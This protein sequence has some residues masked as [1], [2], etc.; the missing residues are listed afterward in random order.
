MGWD[1]AAQAAVP[2]NYAAEVSVG[3]V[4]GDARLFEYRLGYA[5]GPDEYFLA[6]TPLD[7]QYHVFVDSAG[8]ASWRPNDA[9]KTGRQTNTLRVEVVNDELTVYLN[10]KMLERFPRAGLS[11]GRGNVIVGVHLNGPFE[12]AEVEVQ[13]KDFKL[14]ALQPWIAKSPH[15]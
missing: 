12:G 10:G 8:S 7:G 15:C 6:V 5:A 9:V 14:Y 11:L 4:G 3:L 2:A 13:F 1:L